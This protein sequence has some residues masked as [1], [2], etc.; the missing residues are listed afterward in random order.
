[1]K[2]YFYLVPI[3]I[4][5]I[6]SVAILNISVS[7]QQCI[8]YKCYIIRLP[9]Y[10]KV[11]DFFDRHYNYKQL[12]KKIVKDAKIDEER[13]MKILEWTYKNIKRVPEGFPVIDD[14]IW[15]TIVRGYAV[16]DQFSDIF[17]TLCNYAGM[18]AFFTKIYGEDRRV[19]TALSFVKINDRWS[20]FDPYNG[21]YF[22]GRDN[23]LCEIEA[24]GSNNCRPVDIER[25][26]RFDIDYTIYFSDI[27]TQEKGRLSRANIQSPLNRLIYE[28]R[29]IF[30]ICK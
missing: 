23:R 27:Q 30:Q 1:M 11:I 21:I 22:K 17:S 4:F 3:C 26:P 2:K 16:N 10:L 9:L 7:T 12:V 19:L 25:K 8:D 14:H 28:L 18:E 15:Y 29:R 5:I 13:V 20:I 24:M 6:L